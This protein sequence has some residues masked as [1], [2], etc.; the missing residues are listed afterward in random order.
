MGEFDL[1]FKIILLGD[2]GV[3]KTRLI[4]ELS[5]K[6]YTPVSSCCCYSFTPNSNV[7]L[8]FHRYG[9]RI[10]VKI[11]DTGGQEKYRSMTSSYFRGCDGCLLMF[12]VNRK[13]TFE[14]IITWYE[15]LQEYCPA[16]TFTTVLIGTL[17]GTLT[18][19][20]NCQ[21]PQERIHKMAE[22]IGAPYIEMDL[23]NQESIIHGLEEVVDILSRKYTFKRPLYD[24]IKQKSINLEKSEIKPSKSLCGC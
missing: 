13:E 5:K 4:K 23:L 1:S 17:T 8:E 12:S 11:I 18:D 7:D 10:S 6:N 19:D 22:H 20:S 9:K 2:C 16:T 15:S 24:D 14:H 3:G 21:I